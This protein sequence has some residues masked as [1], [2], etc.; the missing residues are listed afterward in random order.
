MDT[1]HEDVCTFMIYCSVL[2]R[3]GNDADKSTTDNQ[4]THFMLNNFFSEKRAFCEITWNKYGRDRQ[5]IDDN[6]IRRMHTATWVTK[7]TNTHSEYVI[8][9]V[10]ARQQ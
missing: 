10:F 4:N 3:M 6:K 9:S 8:L 1:L 5:A 7:A 2:L